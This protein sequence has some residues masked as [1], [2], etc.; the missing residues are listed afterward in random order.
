MADDFDDMIA[1]DGQDLVHLHLALDD[2]AGMLARG[3][4]DAEQRLASDHRGE[5]ADGDRRMRRVEQVGLD[6]DARP[7]RR[8]VGSIDQH[9]AAM[10]YFHAR[11]S[12]QKITSSL[13]ARCDARV[14]WRRAS[15]R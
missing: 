9:D 8:A 3:K 4:G 6:D 1:G 13:D 5:R 11:A 7:R 2:Q 15:R 14:D 10:P 12:C